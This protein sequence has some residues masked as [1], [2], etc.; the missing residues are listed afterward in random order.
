MQK[1]GEQDRVPPLHS[2]SFEGSLSPAAPYPHLAGGSSRS[3]F[4]SQAGMGQGSIHLKFLLDLKLRRAAGGSG[5]RG[6]PAG[7]PG[8][9]NT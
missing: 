2:T 6:A 5:C 4:S 9:Q 3:G 1:K 7:T 8:R